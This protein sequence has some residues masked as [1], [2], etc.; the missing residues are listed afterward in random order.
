MLSKVREESY[1]EI[2]EAVYE[3]SCKLFGID[4]N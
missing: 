3:N 4:L 1:E 2:V